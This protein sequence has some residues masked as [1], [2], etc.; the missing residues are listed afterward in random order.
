[1]KVSTHR[2]KH[3]CGV[4][5][6]RIKE[7]T[8]SFEQILTDLLK[9]CATLYTMPQQLQGF[10][11]PVITAACAEFGTLAHSVKGLNR[12]RRVARARHAVA[13]AAVA[14]GMTHTEIGIALKRD[15]STITDSIG[16]ADRLLAGDQQFAEAYAGILR[17][18]GVTEP[19]AQE[20][21]AA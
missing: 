7:G 13:K 20:A 5:R 14:I 16:A 15:R 11:D 6:K 18:L 17:R 4:A 9:D 19:V 1:M 10:I 21:S 3:L 12:T 2:L 8:D